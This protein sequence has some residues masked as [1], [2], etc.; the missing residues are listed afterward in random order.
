VRAHWLGTRR[1]WPAYRLGGEARNERRR[2]GVIDSFEGEHRWLSNFYPSEITWEGITYRTVE[3]AYQ[4]AKTESLAQRTFIAWLRTPGQAK[5][6]GQTVELRDGWEDMKIG[7]MET[8]LRL[9]FQPLPANQ[10]WHLLQATG[11]QELVKGNWWG[12]TFWGVCQGVGRN[13][14]GKALMR[15]RAGL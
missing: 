15:V 9:K 10:L 2:Y 13:E 6:H 14:L 7:I 1:W 8:L 3:H 12:D 11:D 4:A 5:R